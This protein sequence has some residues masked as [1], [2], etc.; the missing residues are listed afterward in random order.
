M[1]TKSATFEPIGTTLLEVALGPKRFAQKFVVVDELSTTALLGVDFLYRAKVLIDLQGENISFKDNQSHLKIK[2]S[3]CKGN[4]PRD[5]LQIAP[6][7]LRIVDDEVRIAPLHERTVVVTVRKASPYYRFNV[8]GIVSALS[9]ATTKY[10]I[11][12]ARMPS[13]LGEGTTTIVLAN[14]SDKEVILRQG[15]A[16]ANFDA[17]A[18]RKFGDRLEDLNVIEVTPSLD[19]DPVIAP[20]SNHNTWKSNSTVEPT[21]SNKIE[22]DMNLAWDKLD[23]PTYARNSNE[24][25]FVDGWPKGLNVD[26]V[27]NRLNIDQQT[28]LKALLFQYREAFAS[29]PDRP[30]PANAVHGI[31]TGTSGPVK[32]RP[33]KVDH[34]KRQYIAERIEELLHNKVIRPSRSPWSSP[35]VLVPKKDGSIRFCVDYRKLNLATIKDSYPLP[36]QEDLLNNVDKTWYTTL[37]LAAGYWQIPVAEKDI[38]K[39]AFVTHEGLYEFL[40][41]PFGLTN[42]PATFQRVMDMALVGLKWQCCLVYLDDIIVFSNT[43]DQHLQDIEKVLKRLLEQGLSLK[44]SKCNFCAEEVEYLGH[45]VSRH[46]IRPGNRK[47]QAVQEF[48]IP[49]NVSAVRSFLGLTSYYRRFIPNYT[50]IASPLLQLLPHD[51]VW[52]WT[53]SQSHAFAVLKEALISAPILA[54]PKSGRPYTVQTDASLLGLGAILSQK[55]EHNHERVIAYASRVLSPAE[56]KWDTRELE[57]LA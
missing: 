13:R 54:M 55:D 15:Y 23:Q 14:L 28:D 42:A 46:G 38:E 57:A 2:I 8:D 49:E 48:P 17:H 40:V 24:L 5:L 41:M 10:G 26:K 25:E 7:F 33:Y 29:N 9:S 45:I 22:V 51:V 56:K 30:T 4:D 6:Q 34:S 31:D 3:L 35:V 36:L 50:K 52:T 47:V 1:A 32:S 16:V 21:S 43:F 19:D 18:L 12:A 27:L 11:W 53:D 44:A 20:N 39:T 37:D